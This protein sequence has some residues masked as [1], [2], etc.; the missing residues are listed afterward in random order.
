M[1]ASRGDAVMPTIG[2]DSLRPLALRKEGE[3]RLA[4]DW[5]DG[6]R[7]VFAWRHLR[8]HCTCAG[9]RDERARPPD[10]FRILKTSELTP[11]R[12]VAITP[13]GHYAYKIT[14]SDGHDAGIYTLETL[15]DLCQCPECQRVKSEIRNPK[16]QT[17]I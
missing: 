6:H 16:S 9:C 2:S 14:W 3:D 4:I 5:S 11:L 1:T 8:D 7:S 10:P 13:V 17:Q 15:R 12:P